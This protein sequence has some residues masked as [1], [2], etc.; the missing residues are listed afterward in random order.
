MFAKGRATSYKKYDSKA[1]VF[2]ADKKSDMHI[3]QIGDE[4]FEI[5]DAVVNGG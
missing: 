4:R 2:K 3:I 5:P 1:E